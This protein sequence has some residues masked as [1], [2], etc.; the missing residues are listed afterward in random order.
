MSN[1]YND[2]QRANREVDTAVSEIVLRQGAELNINKLILDITS[3]FPVGD[4]VVTK[5]IN[6][7]M[8]VNKSLRLV[9]ENLF[10]VGDDV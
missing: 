3:K 4:K 7:M 10:S 1:Y 6:L 5:R 9:E 2:V 8:K